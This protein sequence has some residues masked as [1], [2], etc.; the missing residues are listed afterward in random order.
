MDK[1]PS[2]KIPSADANS[3][4]I[5]P[6]DTHSNMASPS[7]VPLEEKK[8]LRFNFK[9]LP[10]C[11]RPF[12]SSAPSDFKL[13]VLLSVLC[14]YCALATRLRVKY[15][16][17]IDLHALL[18]QVLICGEPELVSRSPVASSIA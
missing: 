3:N 5:T 6:S 17:D 1:Q 7:A 11:I 12:V 15:P 10:P 8:P 16:Y 2:S 13:A 14:C 18:V 4:K 9:D